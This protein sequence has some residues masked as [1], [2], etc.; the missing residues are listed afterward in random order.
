MAGAVL[1][2]RGSASLKASQ[3]WMPIA[4]VIAGFGVAYLPLAFNRKMIMGTHVP[5]CL[6]AGLAAAAL[7][8]KPPPR[9]LSSVISAWLSRHAQLSWLG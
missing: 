2:L 4:W 7:A 8:E 6:L 3:R 5:L 9:D 1:L